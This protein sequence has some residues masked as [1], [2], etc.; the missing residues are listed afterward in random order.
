M[1]CYQNLVHKKDNI[2]NHKDYSEMGNPF[3]L[4]KTSLRR[5]SK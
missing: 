4:L 5:T 3:N 1:I 2:M